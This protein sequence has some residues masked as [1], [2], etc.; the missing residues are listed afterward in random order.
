M[1]VPAARVTVR[2]AVQSSRRLLRDTLAACLA[3][4]PEMTVIGKV[5]EPDDVF[6]L[7]ELRRPDVVILDA[8]IRLGE[9]AA[10]VRILLR[11]FPGLNV[12][13]MYRE[14][15]EQDLAAACRAGVASLLPE[16]H[17]LPAVLALVKRSKGRHARRADGGL[18]DRELEII[19]LTGSGHSVPDIAELLHISPLT[20]E[21][22]KR[23]VYAKLDVSSSVHAVARAASFGMLDQRAAPASRLRPQAE[24][25]TT[26]LTV[27]SGQPGPTLDQVVTA[28]IASRL[29]FVLVRVPGPVAGTHWAR[30]HRGP[31][32]AALVDPGPPDWPVVAEL[33][34][35]AVLVHGKALDPQELAEALARGASALVAAD[36]V[37]AHFLSVLRMVSQ[38][39]L[40]VDS[41]P[42]RPL[43]GAVRARW[44]ERASGGLELP[45]LTSRESDILRSL[46]LGHS[47]KQTA[48]ALGIAPK[49]V[50]N[51]QTRLFRKLGVRNRAGALAVADGFGLLPAGAQAAAPAQRRSRVPPPAQPLAERRGRTPLQVPA[52]PPTGFPSPEGF[53]SLS[54]SDRRS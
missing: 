28:L 30:W 9:M 39:Y 54:G 29:P 44:D 15:S 42:M 8:G 13:V 7:C 41:M 33:G 31:I 35:P 50:E 53:P 2:V 18:T 21:N 46:A 40:V 51:V 32:V 23:R 24:A 10:R 5:A 6:A 25:G 36:R 38:G 16:S 34:V 26:V 49:T 19:V 12:I 47:I 1:S 17:G 52:G 20:V 48:R 14:A 37:H 22:I 45:E 43:I 27:V 3:V 11:H 4:R